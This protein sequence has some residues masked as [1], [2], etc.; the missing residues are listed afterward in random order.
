MKNS[1]QGSIAFLIC[2]FYLICNFW[3]YSNVSTMDNRI[4]VVADGVVQNR[5]IIAAPQQCGE[6]CKDS[7]YL[8]INGRYVS[9]NADTYNSKAIGSNVKL[10]RKARDGYYELYTIALFLI[11]ILNVIIVIIAG[12][13]L[14]FM[15][16]GFV[17]WLCCDTD[18]PLISHMNNVFK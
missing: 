14:F 15:F 18:E 13:L 11:S 2:G 8:Q 6:Y 16:K 7:Y 3:L 12:F 10:V 5:K 1:V 9:V 4:A 17:R